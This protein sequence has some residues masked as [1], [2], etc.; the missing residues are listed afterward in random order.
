MNGWIAA[1][2]E[3]GQNY[4]SAFYY[5]AFALSLSMV[6]LFTQIGLCIGR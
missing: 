2:A 1:K 4:L 5:R 6:I 3:G